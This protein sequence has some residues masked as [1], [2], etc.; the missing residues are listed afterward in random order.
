MTAKINLHK[1]YPARPVNIP[2]EDGD[3]S[4]LKLRVP[5]DRSNDSIFTDALDVYI[6]HYFPEFYRNMEDPSF[7]GNNTNYDE[8]RV[9]LRPGLSFENAGFDTKPPSA[10][11]LV[12]T[13]L[14]MGRSL[15]QIRNQLTRE[16][17]LPDFQT[18]L[19]FFNQQQNIGSE[20]ISF[21]QMPLE[22]AL[23]PISTFNELMT[24]FSS[25]KANYNGAVPIGGLN[26]PSLAKTVND[27]WADVITGT[28]LDIAGALGE[29]Y[30]ATEADQ[31]TL[32]FGERTGPPP[33]STAPAPPP[34]PLGLFAPDIAIN[35]IVYFAADALAT[36]F[37]KVGYFTMIKYRKIF[38]DQVILKMLRHYEEMVQ[39]ANEHSAAGTQYPMFD[40]LSQRLPEQIQSAGSTGDFFSF[41]TPNDRDDSNQSAQEKEAIRLGLFE[42]N[43]TDDLQLG[44]KALTNE[45][46]A[47]LKNEVAK[48]PELFEKVYQAEK[49][50]KLKNGMDIAKTIQEVLQSGGVGLF[51]KAG[52]GKVGR[53]LE[54]IGIKA[55]AKEALICL[56]FGINIEL[57]RIA[58]I[59]GKTMEEELNERPAM[60]PA[61]FPLFKIKGDIGKIVLD[62]ILEGLKTAL[63]NVIKTLADQLQEVC[64]LNNPRANDFGAVDIADLIKDNF[65]DP[66]AGQDPFGY[67]NDENN[68]LAGLG[69]SMPDI[70][71]YLRD[72][73]SILSS[74][75]ICVLLMDIEGASE[76]L[77]NRIIDF[78]VEY[79]NPRISTKLAQPTPVIEFWTILGSLV[80]VSDL[81]NEILNDLSLLNQDNICL[82][83]D[84]LDEQEMQNIQ[85]LLDIIEN[86]LDQLPPIFNFDCPEA[87]NYINDPVMTRL[88]PETLSTMVEVVEMQFIYST[89]S[90]KNVLLEPALSR[91]DGRTGTGKASGESAYSTA[92]Q[93]VPGAADYPELPE[94]NMEA[95]GA[96]ADALN[97]M[98]EDPSGIFQA[99]ETCIVDTP[100]LL[101]PGV[102][103]AAEA[104]DIII[105]ILGNADVQDA[106]S[107]IQDKIADITTGGTG[108]AVNTYRFNQEF[109]NKFAN[110]INIAKSDYV[111]GTERMA[112]TNELESRI[113]QIQTNLA[114]SSI[115]NSA[116]Q[117]LEDRLVVVQSE[118]A[119][120]NQEMAHETFVIQDHFKRYR[121]DSSPESHLEFS[122]PR[123]NAPDKQFIELE[124]PP[125]NTTT[126]PQPPSFELNALFTDTTEELFRIEIEGTGS[127]P[128][129]YTM[130]PFVNAAVAAPGYDINITNAQRKYFP[131]A[132][133]VVVD[134]IFNYYINNGIFDAAALQS[135]SFFHDNANCAADDIADLLDV[136]GIFK[137]MQQEYLEEA[138]NN[139]PETARERMREVIKFGMFL[140]LV[141]VHVAEFVIKNIFVFGAVK[142]DEL[143]A[144]PFVVSYM[145][146]QVNASIQSYF[147]KSNQQED[148]L[149]LKEAMVTI[150]N[151]MTSRPNVIAAGGI[152]DASGAVVFPL[153]TVFVVE[154][155]PTIVAPGAVI[156]NFNDIV[157]F[158]ALYRIETSMGPEEGPPGPVANAISKSLPVINQKS[159]EEIFL[160]SM[161][162]VLMP[163]QAATDLSST[164]PTIRNAALEQLRSGLGNQ[165]GIVII[166]SLGIEGT[167]PLQGII[168]SLDNLSPLGKTE[169]ANVTAT[170]FEEWVRSQFRADGSV[171]Y[172]QLVSLGLGDYNGV[173][174]AVLQQA[175]QQRQ[176]GDPVPL[177]GDH[178]V[179]GILSPDDYPGQTQSWEEIL[180]ILTQL[181]EDDASA[182][183]ELNDL[184]YPAEEESSGFPTPAGIEADPD[185]RYEF[186]FVANDYVNRIGQSGNTSYGP[187]VASSNQSSPTTQETDNMVAFKLFGWTAPNLRD[188]EAASSALT[189]LNSLETQMILTKPIYQTWFTTV[190]DQEIIGILPII[191]NF[192]L[193]NH[194]FSD[195]QKA[196]RSTKNRV[197]EII[198]TTIDN[199]DSYNQVPD[200]NRGAA[201]QAALRNN[202][203][204]DPE[205]MAR[206]FIIQMLIKTPID[207]LKGVIQLIDP[208]VVISKFIKMG[209][210][211]AFNMIQSQMRQ[212]D[213]P[214]HISVE[215]SPFKE[216]ASGAEL[217]G[218][219]LCL[220]QYLM[221]NAQNFPAPDFNLDGEP[222][223]PPEN[224][225]P[226][227][228][229][230]GVD[231]LGT[232]MGMMMI[233]PTPLGLIYML[234]SLINFD[235]QQA[236]IDVG[237]NFGSGNGVADGSASVCDDELLEETPTEPEPDLLESVRPPYVE[238]EI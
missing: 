218:A 78:N 107:N 157:S 71:Q 179:L 162:V 100:N 163:G 106:L 72:V 113:S 47:Q 32:Y 79:P 68:P 98:S 174:I 16:R 234:L 220:M 43:D 209:T 63:M 210:G 102:R 23:N 75:D 216:G 108:P 25:Q 219:L 35:G 161:P 1:E 31:L 20:V 88:I 217:F 128:T 238:S 27:I 149:K 90:I 49:K 127:V 237:V 123:F 4:L 165:D 73:S 109:Y 141:Q 225:L 137:Q 2:F 191:H 57:A 193:T 180:E 224:F 26:F 155:Q 197:L 122:F 208:H 130:D 146:S 58:D 131:F 214:G 228:S 159:M 51:D 140:L 168:D 176:V 21:T 118:L 56:T 171:N 41:P 39:K 187:A 6:T 164:S 115:T 124:Y 166:K 148:I 167:N 226:R 177:L 186:W 229:E 86:G 178:V 10:K 125:Y 7:D 117:R 17:K 34:D 170:H 93:T 61:Q 89:D 19:E 232:G 145:R 143:F 116:R 53:I 44:I 139:N 101:A 105:D 83:L 104:I 136:T 221:A 84:A 48:N 182:Q 185:L 96:V 91:A 206:D 80:D 126:T 172:P 87:E 212:L 200:L 77:I 227:I 76:E 81:C 46:L 198:K 22:S 152:T 15:Y 65:L 97:K 74:I 119:Q 99:L 204:L 13:R 12:I 134:Q 40:F 110:Y 223:P 9:A 67:G 196:M 121:L 190:F 42:I 114:Q 3:T 199:H 129:P 11:K 55:L 95:L 135:L 195:I 54:Q 203:D 154:G 133:G 156:K 24:S 30:T 103:D 189:E 205:A 147:E 5:N 202:T 60:D 235:T 158:I 37:L 45:E 236:N 230:D 201:R 64:N 213:L 222:D 153:E 29:A 183:N 18:N 69:L 132:Y 28:A 59:V 192:Y 94:P 194:Y 211:E 142:L 66:L 150:F 144:R 82:D 173:F 112:R 207:I 36:D 33:G 50:K 8:L 85:D 111:A 160:S 151:R 231:F 52:G 14:D 120:M 181:Y 70:Y 215:G 175:N 92:L 138:C 184:L 38:N 188:F 233:P 62:A 169:A